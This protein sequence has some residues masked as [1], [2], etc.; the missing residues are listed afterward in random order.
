MYCIRLMLHQLDHMRLLPFVSFT[1]SDF[2]TEFLRHQP[3][4]HCILRPSVSAP[5]ELA[6]SFQTIVGV[7]HAIVTIEKNRAETN[8]EFC[9]RGKDGAARYSTLTAALLQAK[10][11]IIWWY[12]RAAGFWSS[13]YVVNVLP[14]SPL[15]SAGPPQY[16]YLYN[17]GIY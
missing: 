1:T 17:Y 7:S 2:A 14:T 11:E 4:G 5:G 8:Y 16:V 15:P 6:V 13:G 3:A 10:L 12:E 9:V